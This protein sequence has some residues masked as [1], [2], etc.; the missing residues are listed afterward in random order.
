MEYITVISHQHHSVKILLSDGT[1][2]DIPEKELD[3]YRHVPVKR[4]QYISGKPVRVNK[5]QPFVPEPNPLDR[6]YLYKLKTTSEYTDVVLLDNT[7]V[8]IPNEY[9]NEH[10]ADDDRDGTDLWDEERN[11]ENAYRPY[12][13][14][15]S[16]EAAMK[17][18]FEE[19]WAYPFGRNVKDLT[20]GIEFE[21]TAPKSRLNE[22]QNKMAEIVGKDRFAN[23]EDKFIDNTKQWVLGTDSSIS[24]INGGLGCELTTPVFH[25]TDDC[26]KEIRD[27]LDCI[28]NVFHGEVNES[29][30]T[31]IHIGH[32]APIDEGYYQTLVD[33]YQSYLHDKLEQYVELYARFET[34]VFDRL[35]LYS[36]RRNR[37]RYC[38]SCNHCDVQFDSHGERYLKINMTCMRIY[39]NLENRQHHGTLD[40][41]EIW[42]WMTLNGYFLLTC[43]QNPKS[44]DDATDIKSLFEAIHLPMKLRYYY[45]YHLMEIELKTRDYL[46]KRLGKLESSQNMNEMPELIE[47]GQI[48]GLPLCA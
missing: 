33:E 20:F 4:N 37:N 26:A 14:I 24:K 29:C 7:I 17:N 25:L 31:H 34:S 30:G 43:L 47:V 10:Y 13:V 36:R 11:R 12:S 48:H 18:L 9:M 32:F 42:S 3:G 8:S 16:Y 44:L 40:F 6:I 1:I 19:H 21:F 39:Q 5:H 46:N 28:K 22:F 35:V 41:D 2:K 38:Q 45:L 15:Y 23:A 27:V